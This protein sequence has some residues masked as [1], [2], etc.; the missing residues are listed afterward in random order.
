MRKFILVVIYLPTV[1]IM[2]KYVDDILCTRR[3]DKVIRLWWHVCK[4]ACMHAG[5]LLSS[6]L[7]FQQACVLPYLLFKLISVQGPNVVNFYE[8]RAPSDRRN[9][10]SDVELECWKC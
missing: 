6:C 5:K 10:Y 2:W 3:F 4:H 9:Y 1:I 8:N 7:S